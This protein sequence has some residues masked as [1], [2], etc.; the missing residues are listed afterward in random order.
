MHRVIIEG[1][2]N[3]KTVQLSANTLFHFTKKIENLE[4]I[5]RDEFN[6]S[7]C[8]EDWEGISGG[9]VQIAIPMVCFCD[10]PLSQ[11]HN[12]TELY[13]CY[14]LGL[15]KDWGMR[16]GI[17]PI[18]Y[19]YN[20]ASSAIHVSNAVRKLSHKADPGL[21]HID[22]SV[23]LTKPYEGRLWRDGVF[24]GGIR[25]Y[26]EREW[27]YIPLIHGTT[28]K[29]ILSRCEFLD[30]E[31]KKR[32]NE[33]L[34]S[35]KLSFQPTDIKYIIVEKESEIHDMIHKIRHIKGKFPPAD[36]DILTTR[37]M[38]MEHIKEDF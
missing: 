25:F 24:K 7:F 6:P 2:S 31:Y 10:I 37:I 9:N 34:K 11:I 19:T 26:D 5:L 4:S 33:K 15:T 12:H 23:C 29:K 17:S 38:S 32:E 22:D 27:R 1:R 8:L 21:Y 20:G 35:R 18:L 3:M 30:K 14:A 13:G 28:E 36:V 16:N